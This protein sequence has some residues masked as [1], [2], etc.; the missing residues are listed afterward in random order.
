MTADGETVYYDYDL[1]NRL[2]GKESSDGYA[3]YFY[4]N[5][6]NMV[7]YQPESLVPLEVS[8]EP[9]TRSLTAE[10]DMGFPEGYTYNAANQFVN[11]FE[12]NIE[13][14]YTYYPDGK[15]KT[16]TTGAIETVYVW[17]G[18][19]L[20]LEIIDG[21]TYKYIWGLNLVA[22]VN[23]NAKRYYQYDGHG[24]VTK[25]YVPS[26]IVKSYEYDA[27]GNEL[28]PD[29]NDTNPFRYCGEYYDTSTGLYN[30]QARHYSPE[31]G[32]F[33]QEDTHW[34]PSNMLYGDSPV[35]YYRG[36]V[37]AVAECFLPSI[38]A[39]TAF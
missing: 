7:E 27:F 2:V 36:V 8:E 18:D 12:T 31:L 4:D 28:N 5:N 22:Q 17:D 23:G 16:R 33:T 26:I 30:L 21:T 13:N 24:N 19:H 37:S 9:V 35:T 15:R 34:T 14:E 11:T 29:P 39:I 6:G 38:S 10:A 1:A 3:A 20:V 25:L 32:R